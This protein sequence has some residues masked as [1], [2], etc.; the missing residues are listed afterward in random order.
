M[1]VIDISVTP[2]PLPGKIGDNDRAGWAALYRSLEHRQMD[3][4]EVGNALYMGHAIGPILD[5]WR[6]YDHFIR[7]QHI[8]IDMDTEDKAS[9]IS[10]LIDHDLVQMYGAIV[11]STPNSTPT[12]PRSRV[13][14]FLDKPI[15]DPYRYKAAIKTLSAYF[16]GY[17][18]GSAEAVRTFFGNA[19]L[20]KS[21][22]V[23]GM[24]IPHDSCLPLAD[25][26][27]MYKAQKQEAERKA[28]PLPD[29]SQ[30]D[31]NIDNLVK[32]CISK[33]ND[34]QR[35]N[36]GYWLACRMAENGIDRSTAEQAMRYYARSVPQSSHAYTEEEALQSLQS[37]FTGVNV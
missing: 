26:R 7:A 8:G 25:L 30:T 35:N 22:N 3:V 37:A 24:W 11:Y 12:A 33:A 18:R 28:K 9:S 23:D 10:R 6:S 29:Y 4:A 16:P 13:V 17:D 34:G 19:N 14:F 1:N 32:K 27:A 21:H 20:H 31:I 36:I 15:T 2:N 5:G